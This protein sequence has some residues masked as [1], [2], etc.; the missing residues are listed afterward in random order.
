MAILKNN[1]L[2]AMQIDNGIKDKTLG[3]GE[4]N[5]IHASET[6]IDGVVL[7]SSLYNGCS[8]ALKEYKSQLDTDLTRIRNLGITFFE[9]DHDGFSL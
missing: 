1:H 7:N 9:M 5:V 4:G 2:F 8:L 6:N 3:L